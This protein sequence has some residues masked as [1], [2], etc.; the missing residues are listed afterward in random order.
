MRDYL[1]KLWCIQM[2]EYWHH[3]EACI[4]IIFNDMRNVCNLILGKAGYK[5][6][7]LTVILW[8]LCTHTCIE[9]TKDT[10]FLTMFI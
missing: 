2:M 4:K 1:N 3:W 6:K 7:N 10:Q 8:Y 5:T 9:N